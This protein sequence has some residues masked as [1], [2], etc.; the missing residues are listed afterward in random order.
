M[1]EIR[2]CSIDPGE[3][4]CGV[5]LWAGMNCYEVFECDPVELFVKLERTI[6]P[7]IDE[8]VVEEFR[9]YPWKAQ[10]QGFS[11][12]KTAQV[13]GVIKFLAGKAGIVPIMQK[14]QVRK[15]TYKISKA[16]RR[17]RPEMKGPHMRDAWLMGEYRVL[18]GRD[19][20]E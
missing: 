6:L 11:E 3:K 17:P 2:M 19:E 12:M 1:S 10:E 13:I 20:E 14:A 15:P 16:K 7:T 9:V 18:K 5:A 8:L 4:Y